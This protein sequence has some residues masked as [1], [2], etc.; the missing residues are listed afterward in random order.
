MLLRL[1][2]RRSGEGSQDPDQAI[3]VNSEQI[4]VM[5][6]YQ[7]GSLIYTTSGSPKYQ[8]TATPEDIATMIEVNES[9]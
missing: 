1:T 4:V 6:P 3:V 7:G 8:V 5:I 9:G 2:G